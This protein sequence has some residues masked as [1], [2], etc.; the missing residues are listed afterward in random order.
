[1]FV[2]ADGICT[3]GSIIQEAVVTVGGLVRTDDNLEGEVDQKTEPH[4]LRP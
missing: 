1:M 4:A 2:S 3:L